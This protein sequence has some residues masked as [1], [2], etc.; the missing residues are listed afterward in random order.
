[1]H[2]WHRQHT[3]LHSPKATCLLLVLY[4]MTSSA[5]EIFSWWYSFMLCPC[6]YRKELYSTKRLRRQLSAVKRVKGEHHQRK[7]VTTS[8]FLSVV[9]VKEE[10]LLDFFGDTHSS[11][12]KRHYHLALCFFFVFLMKD[13]CSALKIELI[14]FSLLLLCSLNW[15]EAKS[16]PY[17]SVPLYA[18]VGLSDPVNLRSGSTAEYKCDDGYELFGSN[19]RTCSSS[20]KWSGD[21]PYCGKFYKDVLLLS[22]PVFE[23]PR[24]SRIPDKPTMKNNMK[25]YIS[26]LP[27]KEWWWWQKRKTEITP[28]FD[29]QSGRTEKIDHLLI[30]HCVDQWSRETHD[31]LSFTSRYLV[32][33]TQLPFFY[34]RYFAEITQYH[35]FL[36]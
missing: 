22:F 9:I 4:C 24:Q 31:S 3:M 8:F 21:L 12:A 15:I 18:R 11:N 35:F 25:T 29:C 2:T 36:R 17:P 23:T 27:T 26:F 5:G 16:C 6:A 33:T 7:R 28:L 13:V 30:I 32:E 34:C 19:V 20:G 1:M 10:T 14:L